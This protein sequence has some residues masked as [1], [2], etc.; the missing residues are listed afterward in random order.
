VRVECYRFRIAV[1]SN[2]YS[3]PSEY[4]SSQLTLKIYP[5][6]LVIYHDHKLIANHSRS[7]DRHQDFENPDHPKALLQQRLK[8]REQRLLMR[9]LS[10]SSKAEAYYQELAK[11]RLNPR[12]HIRQIVAL[13]E[14]YSA[15]KMT[16]AIEDAFTYQAF[17]CDYIANILEQRERVQPEPGALHVTRRQDLLDLE[18]PEPDLSIY[19]SELDQTQGEDNH[20]CE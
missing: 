9:F 11:R 14:I 15:E 7:Y 5:D 16:R 10:L 1:D 19:D 2:H 12:H 3:V 20:E 17:S 6:R 18:I 8:A 13:S 4:A